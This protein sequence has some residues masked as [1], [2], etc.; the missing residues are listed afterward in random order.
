[1]PEDYDSLPT[2]PRRD[3]LVPVWT[4]VARKGSGRCQQGEGLINVPTWFQVLGLRSGAAMVQP[5][6]TKLARATGARNR[7]HSLLELRGHRRP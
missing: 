7:P 2:R 5:G 6:A 4:M 1:M 3:P